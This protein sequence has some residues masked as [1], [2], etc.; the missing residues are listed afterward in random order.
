M[1]NVRRDSFRRIWTDSPVR[2]RLLAM[3][4]GD[5]QKCAACELASFCNRCPGASFLETGD[6]GSPLPLFCMMSRV[7]AEALRNVEGEEGSPDS[8][9][10]FA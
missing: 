2:R 6:P 8:I 4:W 5:Q 7:A 1:G 10:R 3:R 9:R